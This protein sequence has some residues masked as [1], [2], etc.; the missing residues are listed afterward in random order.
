MLYT[1]I[2]AVRVFKRMFLFVKA[3]KNKKPLASNI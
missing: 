1:A 2:F 3:L